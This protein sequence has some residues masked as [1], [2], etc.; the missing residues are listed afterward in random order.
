MID[1]EFA[2]KIDSAPLMHFHIDL[3]KEFRQSEQL[4]DVFQVD[5][6]V[7]VIS[8]QVQALS[9]LLLAFELRVVTQTAEI[10]TDPLPAH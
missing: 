6:C 3:D 10:T 2:T 4:N 1:D 5:L 8:G 9:L 7:K